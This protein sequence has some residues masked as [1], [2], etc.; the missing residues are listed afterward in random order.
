[1]IKNISSFN[2]QRPQGPPPPPPEGFEGQNGQN[3]VNGHRHHHHHGPHDKGHRPPPPPDMN[4]TQGYGGMEQL[5]SQFGS[6]GYGG[7]TSSLLQ[8]FMNF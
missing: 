3:G 5:L 2:F 1:M 4:Q 8:N 7:Q 6:M